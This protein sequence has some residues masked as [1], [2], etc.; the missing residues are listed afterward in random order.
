MEDFAATTGRKTEEGKIPVKQEGKA[1]VEFIEDKA[2]VARLLG[3]H[4][5][6][7]EKLRKAQEERKKESGMCI[8][9]KGN[10]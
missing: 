8:P 6:K 3:A 5:A 7:I 4:I 9:T 1:V 10:R 2:E